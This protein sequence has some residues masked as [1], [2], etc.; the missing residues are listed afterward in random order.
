MRQRS[1]NRNCT[2]L[3]L[4]NWVTEMTNEYKKP[5]QLRRIARKNE[6]RKLKTLR[7]T[8]LNPLLIAISI[9]SVV[10]FIF[11][12]FVIILMLYSGTINDLNSFSG[13][14]EQIYESEEDEN[15]HAEELGNLYRAEVERRA[16]S[17]RTN[18]II[19]SEKG[20]IA[21]SAISFYGAEEKD[22]IVDAIINRYENEQGNTFSQII[23]DDMI[24]FKQ[25]NISL[26]NGDQ[27]FVYASLRSL[28][29]TLKSSNQA[30]LVLIVFSFLCFV[31]ASHI[32]ADNIS[33]PI[34]EL[35]DHMEVI[36]DGDFTPVSISENSAELHKL[37]AS[38][39]EM[40]ARLEA[41]ND[42]H[43]ISLQNLSHDLRT[44]LMSI[45]GYAEA[46]KYGVMDNPQEA[47]DVIIRESKRLAGVVERLLILSEI[48]TL[49]QPIDMLPVN[50]REF[51]SEEEERI[52][53][54]A[55]QESVEIECHFENDDT[56]VLADRQLLS[57]I[58]SN[59]MS[60]AIRY[61]KSKVQIDVRASDMTTDI[62]VSDDGDGLSEEDL[63]Y[64]FVRYYV[65]KTG[66]SGLGLSA[67]KSAAEYMG[68]TLK[69][70]NR[71]R[72]DSDNPDSLPKGAVFT[73][74]FPKYE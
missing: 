7:K 56:V 11:F 10:M 3:W 64:L 8:V 21:Y 4:Q 40:L 61:A 33:K 49:N 55:M 32:I 42:A 44:P 23:K 71:E 22:E 51:I 41:Y 29:G 50:L 63:K 48:D 68:C 37:T 66:H 72:I 25:V 30:L 35:S 73:V 31:A 26:E 62:V 17:Y 59:L 9:I 46:I 57:T 28:L 60:N 20:E 38:I 45:N 6:N 18:M 34:K 58:I 74:S 24:V 2:W 13:A 14:I 27:C 54:Y 67:A 5:E 65:G 36:G 69:G 47:A 16:V 70:E 53:G 43:T 12:N 1:E 52:E 15:I 19:I 39:N